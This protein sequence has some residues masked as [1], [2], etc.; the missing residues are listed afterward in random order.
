[1]ALLKTL[2]FDPVARVYLWK[3]EESLEDLL[4]G[5]TLH[6]SDRQKFE[7]IRHPEKQREFLG[8]RHCLKA[9]FGENPPVHYQDSGK[10][11]LEASEFISFSHTHGYSA[12]IISNGLNVGLDLELYRPGIRKVAPKYMREEEGRTLSESKDVEH[13]LS[14]WGA[15]EVMLKITGNRKLDFRKQLRV[16]PFHYDVFK[17]TQGNVY[18]NGSSMGVRIYFRE[19][20][21]LFVT[22]GWEMT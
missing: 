3:I 8:L 11:Y 4:Q 18:A 15:K 6:D 12:A 19:L 10:P 22:L 9:H 1:M 17:Q 16:N 20:G 21:D 5:I 13:L 2:N 7:T 14:Y